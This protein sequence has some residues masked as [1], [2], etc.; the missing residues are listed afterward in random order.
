MY[1]YLL[2][3]L[4]VQLALAGQTGAGLASVQ[5]GEGSAADMARED[6]FEQEQPRQQKPGKRL[7]LGKRK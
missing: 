3:E 4:P 7:S 2:E 1:I 6:D 5:P